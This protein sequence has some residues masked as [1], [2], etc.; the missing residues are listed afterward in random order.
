MNHKRL[1]ASAIIGPALAVGL[2]FNAQPK[3]AGAQDAAATY[4]AKCAMCHGANSEKAFDPAKPDSEHVKAILEGVK[5]KMPSYKSM[6]EADA[7]AL[8]D[9]MRELRK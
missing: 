4:K 3:A 6:T 1:I 9:Y 7:Q 8:V 5:P 2:L